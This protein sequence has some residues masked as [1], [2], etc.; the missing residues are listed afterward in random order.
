MHKTTLL[1]LTSREEAETLRDERL[2]AMRRYGALPHWDRRHEIL[3]GFFSRT[4]SAFKEED[5]FR[6]G[7]AAGTAY[8]DG[9][10]A[11]ELK[12]GESIVALAERVLAHY[13]K[14]NGRGKNTVL[15]GLTGSGKSTV[16]TLVRELR[17]GWNDV[18]IDSDTFRYNLLAAPL[19]EIERA[20][21]ADLE[22]IRSS[23]FYNAI[24]PAL[25]LLRHF[26][27]QELRSRGYHVLQNMT[28]PRYACDRLLYLEHPDV[29]PS[30]LDE[31][32][33]PTI[34]ERLAEVTRDR[35]AAQD[36][37]DWANA[38]VITSFADMV[39]VSTRVPASVHESLIRGVR[40]ALLQNP[41]WIVRVPNSRLMRGGIRRTA[42]L[43]SALLIY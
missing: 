8:L 4:L 25:N 40:S 12:F 19:L 43:V 42:E 21:G 11:Y 5:I 34:A 26:I 33:I 6:D 1:S 2:P 14:L 18:V 35:V 13:P 38:R 27:A 9:L 3:S 20:G 22:E 37:Y 16:S 41:E 29:D 36:D 7:E 39:T 15:F 32:E 23:L 28:L 31:A 30:A 17:P 10:L 24:Y